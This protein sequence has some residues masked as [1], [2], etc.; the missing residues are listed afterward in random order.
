MTP[1]HCANLA[2]P[3]GRLRFG[4]YLLLVL[5]R[6]S[7]PFRSS[8]NLRIGTGR[9]AAPI[10]IRR[11]RSARMVNWRVHRKTVEAS[12]DSMTW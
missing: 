3:P 5:T 1:K 8:Q 10:R 7:T 9:F 6:I 4:H 2:G 11:I 12:P